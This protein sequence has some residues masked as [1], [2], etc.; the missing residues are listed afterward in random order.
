MMPY[1][2]QLHD[3][4][5]LPAGTSLDDSIFKCPISRIAALFVTQFSL[6]GNNLT[7]AWN[8]GHW[9]CTPPYSQ[10]HHGFQKLS[11]ACHAPQLPERCPATLLYPFKYLAH[12][13]YACAQ[14]I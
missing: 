3:E 10:S 4:D 12:T 9:C 8:T 11:S 5:A 7:R 13:R 14:A 2:A 6:W 1:I